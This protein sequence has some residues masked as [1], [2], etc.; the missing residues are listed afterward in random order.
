MLYW[1][2]Y[3]T[4]I[5]GVIYRENVKNIHSVSPIEY[6]M[7]GFEERYRIFIIQQKHKNTVKIHM[8]HTIPSKQHPS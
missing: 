3:V 1:F 8:Q 7:L 4:H 2:Q 6:E 5:L